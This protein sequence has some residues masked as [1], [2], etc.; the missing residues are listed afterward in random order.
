MPAP[1]EAFAKHNTHVYWLRGKECLTGTGGTERSVRTPITSSGLHEFCVV[2]VEI[3]I[4]SLARDVKLAGARGQG[5]RRAQRD[6]RSA[7]QSILRVLRFE[8]DI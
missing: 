1:L 8:D 7:A 2:C 4:L 3:G 5:P 6:G